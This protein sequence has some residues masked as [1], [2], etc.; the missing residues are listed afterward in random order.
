M[1]AEHLV[2]EVCLAGDAHR[3]G[4]DLARRCLDCHAVA[5]KELAQ[6]R[7]GAPAVAEVAAQRDP[8]HV[9]VG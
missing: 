7:K 3:P 1:Q 5:R 8:G 9:A 2:V 4:E 6:Q